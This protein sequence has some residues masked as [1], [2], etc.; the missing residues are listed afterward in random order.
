MKDPVGISNVASD[1]GGS[2]DDDISIKD[3]VKNIT[4]SPSLPYFLEKTKIYFEN[5]QLLSGAMEQVILYPNILK[6]FNLLQ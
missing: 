1:V 2:D 4:Q 3:A 6:V 5:A